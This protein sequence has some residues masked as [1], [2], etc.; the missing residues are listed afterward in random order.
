MD[1]FVGEELQERIQ[2]GETIIESQRNV[3]FCYIVSYISYYVLF[4]T[5][6]ATAISR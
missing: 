6:K 1:I 3:S 5:A 4:L 2:S